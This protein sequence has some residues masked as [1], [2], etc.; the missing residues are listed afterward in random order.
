MELDGLNTGLRWLIAVPIY[1]IAYAAAATIF[2]W[3]ARQRAMASDEMLRVMIAGLVGGLV[4]ANIIQLLATGLPGKTIEGG[5]L[6]GWIAVV[7]VKRRLGITAHTG[8]LFALAIP[9]GE[10]I[11]RI[12]CFIGGCCYGK[13]ANGLAWAVQDHGALRHPTQLYMS[14][15]AAFCFAILLGLERRHVLPANGLFYLGGML[16]CIDR[17]AIEFFRD[18]AT[19]TPFGLTLAQTGCL[20]GFAIFAALFIRLMPSPQLLRAR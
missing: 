7:L 19:M 16:F 8:D 5:I 9:L 20:I 6:G 17:F 15:G 14:L 11:G 3:A 1:A 18:G 13:I 12:A 2:W 10:A 4:G